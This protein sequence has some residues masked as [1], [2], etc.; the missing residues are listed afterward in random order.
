MNAGNVAY[1]LDMDLAELFARSVDG[2]N[3]RVGQV[4]PDQWKAATPCTEWDV[5]AL[6]NHVVGEQLWMPPLFHGAT[7]AEVGD[8][9]DGD[10][11]GDDPV[12][13]A[14]RSA[15]EA[16][17]TVDQPGALDR[18]VNLSFG[19][20]PARE[21]VLQL[22]ADHLVHAWDLSVAIGVDRLLDPGAV[23]ACAEWFVDREEMYRAGGATGPRL[24][25]DDPAAG[26]Q[27]R[28]IAAFGRDPG[29]P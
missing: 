2:F 4:E 29:Q 24:V 9:F 17:A 15:D 26:E 20:T 10:L 25:A 16:R 12:A 7:I 14:T 18:T 22:L 19:E 21:Y 27:D 23:H 8:R 6:V 13:T 5:R 1:L 3:V 28:L 11:L